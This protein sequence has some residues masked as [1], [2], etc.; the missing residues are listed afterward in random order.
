MCCLGSRAVLHEDLTCMPLQELAAQYTTVVTEQLGALQEG[1]GPVE[2][3]LQALP[4]SLSNLHDYLIF[5]A[6][7]IER[8]SDTVAAARDDFLAR[9]RQVT[10]P[11]PAC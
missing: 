10:F 1:P 8:L 5:V 7:R 9:R 3:T 2:D 11:L 4:A 6:A